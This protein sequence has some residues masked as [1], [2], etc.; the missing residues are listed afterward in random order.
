VRSAIVKR[1]RLQRYPFDA[2]MLQV[3]IGLE[4]PLQAVNLDVVDQAPYVIHSGLLLP[5]WL[6]K[7]Y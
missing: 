1:W 3:M 4:D 7:P 6:I 2:Q 5:G